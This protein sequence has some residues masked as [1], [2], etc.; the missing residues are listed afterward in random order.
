MPTLKVMVSRQMT[1]FA[2]RSSWLPVDLR[3][4]P[5]WRRNQPALWVQTF[6]IWQTKVWLPREPRYLARVGPMFP[7]E[8]WRQVEQIS[9]K[10]ESRMHWG[11]NRR[12]VTSKDSAG[13][14]RGLSNIHLREKKKVV[15]DDSYKQKNS[16]SSTVRSILTVH[17][18]YKR[19]W[20]HRCVWQEW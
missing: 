20:E 16:T 8:T 1:W 18:P 2:W 12:L 10:K 17:D 14:L 13:S 5:D 19:V 6:W 4:W 15:M 9:Q 3:T 11:Q 7:V